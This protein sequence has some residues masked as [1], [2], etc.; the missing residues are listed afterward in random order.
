M[1]DIEIDFGEGVEDG[2]HPAHR[3]DHDY[4]CGFFYAHEA[5]YNF[6]CHA[7]V[8]GLLGDKLLG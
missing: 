5:T 2:T 3:F 1:F 6:R 8:H 4:V 7:R